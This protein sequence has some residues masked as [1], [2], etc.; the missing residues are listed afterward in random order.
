MDLNSDLGEGFGAW[1]MGD[2]DALLGVVTSA[3]VACGFHA[4]D[5]TTMRS[6]VDV[7]CRLGVAIGAH[8]SYDDKRGFGRRDMAVDP[9]ELADDVLYQIGALDAFARAAGS[10]V[11]YVKAHGA[12][13]NRA[14]DDDSTAEALVAAVRAYGAD[15]ALLHLPGSAAARAAERAGVRPVAEGFADRAYGPGGRLVPRSEPG[16]VIDDPATVAERAV[17]MATEGEVTAVDGSTIPL[18]VESICVHGDTPGALRLA[19][20][21]RAALE[22]ADVPVGPFVGRPHP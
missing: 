2:D 3:N 10:R 19:R 9:A 7:A 8:V 5:P 21:V 20:S 12:L 6:V 14:A 13:Y 22:A 4:G 11:G 18:R 1:R 16:A 15:L 17:R